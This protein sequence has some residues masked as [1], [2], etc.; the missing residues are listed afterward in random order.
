VAALIVRWSASD[1]KHVVRVVMTFIAV[2]GCTLS[3]ALAVAFELTNDAL[4]VSYADVHLAELVAARTKP[5]AIVATAASY[6]DPVAMLSGRRVLIA[7]PLMLETHGIDV[8][9]RARDLVDLYLG[10]ARADEVIVRYG[11][12]AVIVG[13][14]ERAD[15]PRVNEAFFRRRARDMFEVD[16][17]RLYLLR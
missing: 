1:A 10:G 7:T 16:G 14:H 15:L 12:S 4:V 3:G 17:N 8:R 2:L 13:P 11:V 6:H 9:A 5:S